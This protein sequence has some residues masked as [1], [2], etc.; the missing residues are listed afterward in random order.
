[1][2]VWNK[3]LQSRMN[4]H[5]WCLRLL[6]IQCKALFSINILS[7]TEAI[8]TSWTKKSF[9]TKLHKQDMEFWVLE[10]RSFYLLHMRPIFIVSQLRVPVLIDYEILDIKSKLCDKYSMRST[11]CHGSYVHV[12]KKNENLCKRT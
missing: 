10:F 9:T 5:F 1:M 3:K 6:L 4:Y 7:M 12:R 11:Q 8:W 2:F